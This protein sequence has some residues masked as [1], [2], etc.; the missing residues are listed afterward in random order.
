MRLAYFPGCK[1]SFG[2]A[3]YGEAVEA[4][5]K[6]LGVTLV[7]L[8]FNCCGNPARSKDLSASVLASIRNLTM[9]LDQGLDILTPCKCCFGQFKHGLH[10][11]DTDKVIREKVD[12]ALEED[13]LTFP[14]TG[15]IQDPGTGGLEERPPK[16]RHL[17]DFLYHDI[18]TDTLAGKITPRLPKP[19]VVLQQGCHA[20]R[21]YAVTRFDNPFNPVMFGELARACGL[22]TVSWSKETECCGDPV[23]DTHTD[24][25]FR[26]RRE[27]LASAAR[28]GATTICTAC[29]HCQIQ[30]DRGVPGDTGDV[31]AVPFAMLLGRALGL[32]AKVFRIDSL[33]PE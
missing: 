1:I 3:E 4:L 28:T 10:W 23:A 7:K 12:L 25:A 27:K 32:K 26:M 5:M 20:L 11:Y 14:G 29:T 19:K 6:H 9:A 30:Y 16:V 17:L 33:K 31:T 21:P 13:G 22:E 24:L 2:L 18:G 8:P 15:L